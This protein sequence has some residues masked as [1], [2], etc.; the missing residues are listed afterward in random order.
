MFAP[1]CAACGKGITP[2]E[3]FLKLFIYYNEVMI[4]K[5][6]YLKSQKYIKRKIIFIFKVINI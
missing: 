5:N 2:V 6:Y 3:V 4:S 1:K